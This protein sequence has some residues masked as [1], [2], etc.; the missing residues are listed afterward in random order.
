LR[1][2]EFIYQIAFGVTLA[3]METTTGVTADMTPRFVPSNDPNFMV[4]QNQAAC[5]SCHGGGATSRLHGYAVFADKWDSDGFT[6]FYNPTPKY[7]PGGTNQNGTLGKSFGSN[8]LQEHRNAVADCTDQANIACN[9]ASP[10]VDSNT[11]PWDLSL[12]KSTGLLDK[13]GWKGAITGNGLNALGIAVGQATLTYQFMT[14]RVINQ[15]CPLGSFNQAQIDN[16]ASGAMAKEAA[17]QA[18]ATHV[19]A[20]QGP[21]GYIVVQ[22]ATDPSCQ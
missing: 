17:A 6:T 12:W 19:S 4:G 1:A 10:G 11:A 16:I 22:V 9:P 21:Y 3:S 15:I 13:W 7:N 8:T 5:I 14:Q 20:D 18:S 2:I